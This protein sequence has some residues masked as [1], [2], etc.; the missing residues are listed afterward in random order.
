MD[1]VLLAFACSVPFL[2]ASLVRRA[3][4]DDFPLVECGVLVVE[5]IITYLFLNHIVI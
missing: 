4:K 3:A 5:I 1:L 2:L